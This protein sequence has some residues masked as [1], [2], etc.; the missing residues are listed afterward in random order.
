MSEEIVVTINGVNYSQDW[1]SINIQ[2]RLNEIWAADVKL[3]V[4]NTNYTN[5]ANS[6]DI[7]V[8]YEGTE[9]LRNT[10]MEPSYD[11]DE[12]VLLKTIRKGAYL[13]QRKTTTNYSK[14]ATATSTIVSEL[15]ALIPV[16]PVQLFIGTNTNYGNIDYRSQNTNV[17]LSLMRLS[18]G[19]AYDWWFDNSG[20]N[21]RF[22]INTRKGS[23]SPVKTFYTYGANANC[24]A[25]SR[26]KDQLGVWN[27]VKVK[28]GFGD[29]TT[30]VE[31]GW[32]DDVPSQTA[33][34]T[35][36]RVWTDKSLK[37]VDE[38]NRLAAKILADRKDPV[39]K[40]T[41]NIDDITEVLPSL[42]VT[43][44]QLTIED[45]NIFSLGETKDYKVISRN[46]DLSSEGDI[47]ITLE[48]ASR[49]YSF[50]EELN[51]I[52]G[53]QQAFESYQQINDPGHLHTGV[54]AT[55]NHNHTELAP[56]NHKHDYYAP[57]SH[58]H[59]YNQ[60]VSHT[61]G[62][63]GN[64]VGAGGAA[65]ANYV[66]SN[67]SRYSI[68]A[69][70]S[71]SYTGMGNTYT[72]SD[73]LQYIQVCI[74]VLLESI[75]A[76][77]GWVRIR[78]AD[79]SGNYFPD[80][81]AGHQ[82]PVCRDANNRAYISS[83]IIYPLDCSGRTLYVE[84]ATDGFTCSAK[85]YWQMNGAG[86]HIHPISFPSGGGSG[87]SSTGTSGGSNQTQT[88]SWDGSGASGPNTGD[89]APSASGSSN[90]SSTGV[91]G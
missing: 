75:S 9:I 72:T 87:S 79:S 78:V 56:A 18:K 13:A 71:G 42:V 76:A 14:T 37:T 68:G 30:Q 21:E 90:T 89:A 67:D 61:H 25:A 65:V 69:F 43:G 50:I 80:A 74:G 39:N 84:G 62:V 3:A 8:T 70:L 88:N 38:C 49:T 57:A 31:S 85:W 59:P 16:T 40:F 15:I 41:L 73:H 60:P 53:E 33:W 46:I 45:N 6:K 64:T 29:G 54:Y 36:E 34:G 55:A 81:G 27:R 12:N 83:T 63:D 86:T 82:I 48:C 2:E 44:D 51:D 24:S 7:L 5:I 32:Y 66:W 35:R 11:S 52:A 4:D 1:I 77:T 20:G 19:I 10:I 26:N 17:M 23:A 58:T 28:G 22:N 91:T 47:K